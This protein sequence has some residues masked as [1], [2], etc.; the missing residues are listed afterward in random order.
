MTRFL[1]T[2]SYSSQTSWLSR[3]WDKRRH[4]LL[5]DE[6]IS[7]GI[8][9]VMSDNNLTILF[10]WNR[11]SLYPGARLTAEP[12]NLIASDDVVKLTDENIYSMDNIITCQRKLKQFTF[13]RNSLILTMINLV[14]DRHTDTFN[15]PSNYIHKG[16]LTVTRMY[17]DHSEKK[18]IWV[19]WR[20]EYPDSRNGKTYMQQN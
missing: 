3:D 6:T 20:K 8:V 1:Q 12:L 7:R 5:S 4:H 13:I 19:Q 18:T 17:V 9:H 10:A 16:T 14:L 15:Q 2:Q 11:H